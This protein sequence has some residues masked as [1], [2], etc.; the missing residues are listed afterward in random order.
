MLPLTS[1]QAPIRQLDSASQP[2]AATFGRKYTSIDSNVETED[3]TCS[4]H[5]GKIP[6]PEVTMF[7]RHA[8]AGPAG[9]LLLMGVERRLEALFAEHG[10]A[11]PNELPRA[12]QGELLRRAIVETTAAKAA[13]ADPNRLDHA[14]RSLMHPLF[15]PAWCRVKSLMAARRK[16]PRTSQQDANPAHRASASAS[17]PWL[18]ARPDRNVT[19]H[20]PAI[21][22]TMSAWWCSAISARDGS[23]SV[24]ANCMRHRPQQSRHPGAR[25]RLISAVWRASD[26]I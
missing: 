11:A 3:T 10:A 16:Q 13:S 20:V 7:N 4:S 23:R 6:L 12:L 18:P 8:L 15:V 1:G 19:R 9:F 22:R 2:P 14:T 5:P 17:L 21:A 26:V 24:T 25:R